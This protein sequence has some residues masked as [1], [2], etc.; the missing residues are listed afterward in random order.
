V[1]SDRAPE[2]VPNAEPDAIDPVPPVAIPAVTI[3]AALADKLFEH[4]LREAPDE[5]CGILAGDRSWA[6]GGVPLRFYPTKNADRSP[7]RYRIDP[8]QQLR[9]MLE[10]DDRDEVV[11]GNFHSHTH[12]PAEPSATDRR[13]AFYAGTLYLIASLTDLQQPELRGWT[14]V[15]EDVGEVEL[16]IGSP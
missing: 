10:I 5:A 13:L 9:V 7:Y 1:V 11:W 12:T 15:G 14:I 2:G 8:E 16:A 4:A 3:S 6:K